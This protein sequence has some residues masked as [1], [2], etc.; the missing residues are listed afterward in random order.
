M[1]NITSIP[2]TK[3]SDMDNQLI[4]SDASVIERLAIFSEPEILKLSRLI[5]NPEVKIAVIDG[6]IQK[7]HPETSVFSVF[8]YD[9]ADL[10]NTLF[11]HYIQKFL[12]EGNT[13]AFAAESFFYCFKQFMET[14]SIKSANENTISTM[15]KLVSLSS[16]FIKN[17]EK[18]KEFNTL[19]EQFLS[20]DSE[21]V[22]VAGDKSIVA[23]SQA[24]VDSVKHAFKLTKSS[25]AIGILQYVQQQE[26]A[27]VGIT[28]EDRAILSGIIS[29]WIE[30]IPPQRF[31]RKALHDD[32][33]RVFHILCDSMED[34]ERADY[35]LANSYYDEDREIHMLLN[36]EVF[37]KVLAMKYGPDYME[38]IE[39]LEKILH[40]DVDV[41]TKLLGKY[42]EDSRF[43][44]IQS[45]PNKLVGF[46]TENPKE[47]LNLTGFDA[48]TSSFGQYVRTNKKNAFELGE[49][50][51]NKEFFQA[52]LDFL[53]KNGL[54][55]RYVAGSD[56]SLPF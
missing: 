15:K 22:A 1:S 30:E 23:T 3:K 41:F 46:F 17:H 37:S 52:Y 10:R 55:E 33:L 11:V 35:L 45:L 29:K 20:G 5:T 6:V 42:L 31:G 54:L 13:K 36:H 43:D 28:D 51:V 47:Y 39:V 24:L 56:Y 18:S 49:G 38:K 48:S 9:D 40:S 34:Q 14:A 7:H 50:C 19:L 12:G 26:E 32:K 16:R 53:K 4:T 2:Q 25:S 44:T 27:K 8:Q 21:N